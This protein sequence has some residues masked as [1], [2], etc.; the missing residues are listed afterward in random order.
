MLG[1]QMNDSSVDEAQQREETP[2]AFADGEFIQ[3][4]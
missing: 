3:A 2:W 4:K 1:Q